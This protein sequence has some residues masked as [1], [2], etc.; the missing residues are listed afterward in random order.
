MNVVVVTTAIALLLFG[1]SSNQ[2][3]DVNQL[4]ID[5][6]QVKETIEPNPPQ[7]AIPTDLLLSFSLISS[8]VGICCKDNELIGLVEK[9]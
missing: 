4:Y 7:P 8:T 2:P 3:T 1:C 6:K 5:S 9:V